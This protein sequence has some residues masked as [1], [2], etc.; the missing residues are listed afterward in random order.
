VKSHGESV[1]RECQ[2]GRAAGEEDERQRGARGVKPEGASDDE[3]HLVVERF[4][5]G[6]AQAQ[7]AGGE[8][9]LAVVADRAAEAHEWRQS[10]AGQAGEEPVD[11]LLD[12]GDGQAGLEDLT[13][14]FLVRP[15]AG[16]LPA[17]GLQRGERG[18]LLVGE[19]VGVLQQRPAIALGAIVTLPMRSSWLCQTGCVR[20]VGS[21]FVGLFAGRCGRGSLAA[22][23]A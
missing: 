17:C 11:Q 12:G 4:R 9:P 23:R 22:R 10:A 1:V 8:D 3:L 7:A 20:R 18:G 2:C 16:N 15:G 13:D 21:V 19:L 6:V 14:C 5:A